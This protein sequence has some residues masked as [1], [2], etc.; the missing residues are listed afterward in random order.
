MI[1][2]LTESDHKLMLKADPTS[3][4][5][6]I[7]PESP[8]DLPT[9]MYDGNLFQAFRT[10]SSIAKVSL[11]P[12]LCSFFPQLCFQN[13]VFPRWNRNSI[14]FSELR[15]SDKSLKHELGT[16]ERS[17]L[18]HMSC[19]HC[20]SIMVSNTIDGRFKPF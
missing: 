12:V 10:G 6:V 5:L 9:S 14:E 2:K 11:Y 19:W 1:L 16:I 15:K 7:E 20:G 3:A 4:G 13:G 17:C 18:S 8:F